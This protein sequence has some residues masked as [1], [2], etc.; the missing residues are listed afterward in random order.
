MS[1]GD[2]LIFRATPGGST[3]TIDSLSE[4]ANDHTQALHL[5][6]NVDILLVLEGEDGSR[7]VWVMRQGS[8]GGAPGEPAD[9]LQKM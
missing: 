5:K 9:D 6:R 1:E 7:V 3:R 8:L 4:S 2:N